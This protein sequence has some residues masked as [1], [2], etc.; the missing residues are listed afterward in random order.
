[1]DKEGQNM[2]IYFR[3]DGNSLKYSLDKFDEEETYNYREFDIDDNYSDE[4]AELLCQKLINEFK[5]NGI[6]L[7]DTLKDEINKRNMLIESMK[8][9]D[10]FKVVNSNVDII[11]LSV[12]LVYKCNFNDD[13]LIESLDINVDTLKDKELTWYDLYLNRKKDNNV[14]IA[15]VYLERNELY[16][17]ENNNGKISVVKKNGFAKYYC[18]NYDDELLISTHIYCMSKN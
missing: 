18:E 17:L 9:F 4:E 11:R 5:N 16:F 14:K 2:K 12:Y 8:N 7:S 10:T 15:P 1:M 6:S 3:T 13:R